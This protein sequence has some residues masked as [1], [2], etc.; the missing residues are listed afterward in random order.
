MAQITAST[1]GPSGKQNKR[2]VTALVHQTYEAK[3]VSRGTAGEAG[4]LRVGGGSPFEQLVEHAPEGKPVGAR[5]VR[6]A[7][8]QHFGCHVAV[9]TPARNVAWFSPRPRDTAAVRP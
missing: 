8:G 6:R 1:N 5:V 9:C 7:L 3:K 4:V 2:N